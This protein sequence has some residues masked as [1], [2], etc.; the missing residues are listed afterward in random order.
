MSLRRDINGHLSHCCI[1]QNEVMPKSVGIDTQ[2]VQTSSVTFDVDLVITWV[3]VMVCGHIVLLHVQGPSP[4]KLS[5]LVHS[6]MSVLITLMK[7]SHVMVKDSATWTI[8]KICELHGQS[9]PSDAL[10]P[11]VE[12]LLHALEDSPRVC[13]KVKNMNIFPLYSTRLF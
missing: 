1:P 8:G 5:P 7:D 6:A 4:E 2:I 9:I 12:A 11:L 13:S 3:P 10:N